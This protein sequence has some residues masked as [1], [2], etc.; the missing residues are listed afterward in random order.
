[1]NTRNEKKIAKILKKNPR[2]HS[3]LSLKSLQRESS[4]HDT[5]VERGLFSWIR[6]VHAENTPRRASSWARLKDNGT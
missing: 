1:M 3:R 2:A 5:V 4:R 6:A